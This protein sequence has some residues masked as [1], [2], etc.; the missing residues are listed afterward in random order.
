MREDDKRKEYNKTKIS[1][2]D[3]E[4]LVFNKYIRIFQIY[5][6]IIIML[7][8]KSNLTLSEQNMLQ[9]SK[10]RSQCL[11]DILDD[12]SNNPEKSIEEKVIIDKCYK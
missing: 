12:L 1:F 2:D 10:Q 5:K 11:G 3:V 9:V 8:K 4:S 7:E 6:I